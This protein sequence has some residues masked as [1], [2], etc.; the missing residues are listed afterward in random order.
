MLKKLT[1][2]LKKTIKFIILTIISIFL[3]LSA[4]IF[5]YKPTYSVSINRSTCRIHRKQKRTSSK[6]KQLHR[7]RRERRK[8]GICTS[9]KFTRI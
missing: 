1:V 4:F 9:G 7:R 6:N 3:I 2:H 5:L 8:C